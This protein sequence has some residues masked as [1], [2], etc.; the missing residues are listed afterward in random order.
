M[1]QP[2]PVIFSEALNV[3]VCFG[4]GMLCVK[5]LF[6]FFMYLALGCPCPYPSRCFAL[7]CSALPVGRDMR[8]RWFGCDA[9]SCSSCG[10]CL[11]FWFWDTPHAH[12]RR[13]RE[14]ERDTE[15]LVSLFVYDFDFRLSVGAIFSSVRDGASRVPH[16]RAVTHSFLST[17]NQYR[18]L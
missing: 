9:P 10:F 6:T 13:Q 16:G 12:T 15:R 11:G 5:E 3:S 17:I 7:L 14:R 4:C 18:F 1:A 8:R 2:V